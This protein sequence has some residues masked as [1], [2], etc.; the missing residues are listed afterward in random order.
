MTHWL[1]GAT[2]AGRQ[3]LR[4]GMHMTQCLQQIAQT[5][6][7][8]HAKSYNERTLRKCM[9]AIDKLKA[10]EGDNDI[11]TVVADVFDKTPWP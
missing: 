8:L 7:T 2:Q 1:A 9:T 4:T 3:G 6:A 11:D 10:F 5:Q